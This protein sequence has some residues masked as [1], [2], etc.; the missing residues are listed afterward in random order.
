MLRGLVITLYV[1]SLRQA[2]HTLQ[3]HV[4]IVSCSIYKH[5]LEHVLNRLNSDILW[6]FCYMKSVTLT[7]NYP[8]RKKFAPSHSHTIEARLYCFC[9]ISII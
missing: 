6:K 5:Y 4:F 1:K 2:A 7:C 9:L 8:V 3:K